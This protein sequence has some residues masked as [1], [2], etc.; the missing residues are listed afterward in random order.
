MYKGKHDGRACVIDFDKGRHYQDF[1]IEDVKSIDV[2]VLTG[3]E[4]VTF[5][6][7]NG[8]QITVD[9]GDYVGGRYADFNDGRYTVDLDAGDNRLRW[10]QR[11]DSY[12]VLMRKWAVA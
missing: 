4:I 11:N 1:L 3:D 12:D 2:L 8:N 5:H 9:A 6:M 10:N 7:R